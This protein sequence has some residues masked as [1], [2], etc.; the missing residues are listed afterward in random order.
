[1]LADA[2]IHIVVITAPDRFEQPWISRLAREPRVS[3][4]DRVAPIG[5]AVDLVQTIQPHLVIVDLDL[6]Q[7]EAC[8]RSI[9]TSTPAT[10]CIAVVP[11][12]DI[13][14]LRRLVAAGARD[15]LTRPVSEEELV[16]SARRV[17][18]VEFDRRTQALATTDSAPQPSGRGKL[19][20]L[21]SPKGGTGT[22]TLATNL[23]VLLKQQGSGPVTLVD[24]SL[25]FGDV[26]VQM[27]IFSKY[28]THDLL[29]NVD[30]IDDAM[31]APVLQQHSSGVQ[32]LLAPP[33][34][35]MAGEVTGDQ[36][37]VLMDQLLLRNAYVVVDTWSFLDE[38]A[39]TLLQRADE[40]VV[41]STAEMPSLRRTRQFF[42]Y[43]RQQGPLPGRVSL[44]LNRFPIADGIG[45][46][47]IEQHVRHPVSANIP[48]EGRL[49]VHSVNRGIPLVLLNPQC[50]A[51]RN[52]RRL[53]A[54]I[55][56]EQVNALA[57]TPDDGSAKPAAPAKGGSAL[58]RFMRRS[59]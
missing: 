56:G 58:Q 36:V 9:F 14:G 49:A 53:A 45:L 37:E 55:A 54:L 16:G 52:M 18:S 2:A 50:W 33:Q 43:T 34:P 30:E 44:V 29:S 1:M 26:G 6:D 22:T 8:I 27:N 23:A 21:I 24:F 57:L 32:V 25:Q 17:L 41:V 38:V 15:V 3:Q 19:V 31:L 47:E 12:A 42:E 4:V 40:V 35:E 48:S 7:A 20:V 59:A 46:Q 11:K 10:L 5:G 28:T 13:S 39:W 51:A